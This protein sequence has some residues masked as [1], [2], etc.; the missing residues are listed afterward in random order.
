MPVVQF[1]H[2]SSVEAS[3]LWKCCCLMLCCY[4]ICYINHELHG[5]FYCVMLNVTFKWQGNL[6]NKCP[7]QLIKQNS[8]CGD[9]FNAISGFTSNSRAPGGPVTVGPQVWCLGR[10][11]V[12]SHVT[13]PWCIGVV[14]G[15]YCLHVLSKGAA[16]HKAVDCWGCLCSFSL[17]KQSAAAKQL[18]LRVVHTS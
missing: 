2:C 5:I 4:N 17:F 13:Y 3:L 12:P 7:K 15:K 14:L 16:L 6:C 1:I 11:R 18:K 10:E 8:S 9:Y